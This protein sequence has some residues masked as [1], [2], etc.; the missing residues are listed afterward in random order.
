MHT[1]LHFGGSRQSGGGGGGGSK[2][3]RV[4]FTIC[5]HKATINYIHDQ[6][7]SPVFFSI[8]LFILTINSLEKSVID[9]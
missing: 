4:F 2:Q 6:E 7:D 9:I 3:D 5:I 8:I 1:S